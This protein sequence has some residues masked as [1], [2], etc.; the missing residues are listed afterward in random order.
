MRVRLR[1]RR[2]LTPTL[3]WRAAAG[4]G[5]HFDSAPQQRS[6]G[7]DANRRVRLREPALLVLFGS[8]QQRRLLT[9]ATRWQSAD[10]CGRTRQCATV[11]VL[12]SSTQQR[13][14]GSDANRR[15]RLRERRLLVLFVSTQQRRLLTHTLGGDQQPEASA[16][17]CV[18]RQHSRRRRRD[19]AQRRREVCACLR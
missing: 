9:R 14:S 5:P 12:F 10:G 13:S 7:S 8:T 1:E 11:L 6:D 4:C 19:E 2:L 18:A 15:V 16:H 17:D 3:E